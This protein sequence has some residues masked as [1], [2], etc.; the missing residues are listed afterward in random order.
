MLLE[1][2]LPTLP[3]FD[4]PISASNLPSVDRQA[5]HSYSRIFHDAQRYTN[6]GPAA[7]ILERRLAEFHDAEH[8]VVMASGFWALVVAARAVAR[9]G[10]RY[11]VMPSLTYRRMGDAMAWAGLI[12][13]FCEVDPETLA[14]STD[15]TWPFLDDDVAL[16]LGV[17]PMVNCCDVA[18]LQ[19]MAREA[20]VPL[21]MDA[22]ESPYEVLDGRRVG[23]FDFPEVFSL[24][25]SKML[26]G[27]EGGYITTNDAELAERLRLMRG[28]GF[29]GQDNVELFGVNAKLNEIHAAYALAC[30]DGLEAQVPGHRARYETY[31]RELASVEGLRLVEY[32]AGVRPSYRQ[33]VVEIQ[34]GWPHS[35]AATLAALNSEGALA[36]PYYSPALHQK[37]TGY[38]CDVRDLPVTDRLAGRFM[39]MPSGQRVTQGHVER[40]VGY[41]S[42]LSQIS[43]EEL[44]AAPAPVGPSAPAVVDHASGGEPPE[45]RMGQA[46]SPRS[47]SFFHDGADEGGRT[48]G[49]GTVRRTGSAISGGQPAFERPVPV[50][51]LYFPEWPVYEAMMDGILDRGWYTNHGPLARQAEEQLAALYGVRHSVTVTNATIG[52]MA[53]VTAL[54]IRGPVIVP[55]FTFAATAQALTWAG[56]PVLFCDVDPDTHHVTPESLSR[57]LA[58]SPKGCRPDAVLAVNL[59]GGAADGAAL[60][61]FCAEHELQLIFDSAHGSGTKV[62]GIPLGGRGRAEIFSFHAT[63]ILSASE[64][65]VVCTNDDKLAERIRNVRSSYGVRHPVPVPVTL[66]GR[67]SEAQAAILLHSVADLPRRISRNKEILETYRRSLASVPGLGVLEPGP[68]VESNCSY[69]VVDVDAATFGLS[70][71]QLVEVLRAENV[72]AR[73]YFHPGVHLTPPYNESPQEPLPVTADLCERVLQ[74]PLGALVSNADAERIAAVIEAAHRRASALVTEG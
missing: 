1:P 53:A 51:Q 2:V 7:S 10:R 35:R 27:M 54:G 64:G 73:R 15:S 48:G 30:L 56:L 28:F 25:A 13:R 45:F 65:G 31:Q 34:E 3:L 50:G 14:M 60:E 71:D 24:H 70:R 18:G 29:N 20:Q 22:V 33:I 5:F 46:R 8:C 61:D 67:F 49:T 12:P 58:R 32:D 63:K 42:A 37:P 38:P 39:L 72:L 43:P 68:G 40:L 19:T 4:P 59:W 57:A 26:S 74:L 62:A 6:T 16:V 11:V 23:S 66:N 21:L 52:I 41:L 44:P 55:A 47:G 9:P 69:A 17:H 36:R